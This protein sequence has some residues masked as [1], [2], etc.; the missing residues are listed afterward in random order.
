[1]AKKGTLTPKDFGYWEWR[2]RTGLRGRPKAFRDGAHLW[3]VACEYFERVDSD[4]YKKNDFVKGGNSAGTIVKLDNMRPYTWCGLTDYVAE[5]G[6]VVTLE[7]YRYNRD[8]G[9]EKYQEAINLIG[10]VI[11]SRNIDGASVGAFNANIIAR[12]QHL[13]D[14]TTLTV[15]EEQPLFGDGEPFTGAR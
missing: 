14:N 12:L 2:G 9:Y 15:K 4:P 11:A 8:G 13:S 10:E 6:Y 5:Q 3:R 1:M 7:P